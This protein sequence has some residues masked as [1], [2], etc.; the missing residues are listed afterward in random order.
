[1][2]RYH[3]TKEVPLRSS[4]ARVEFRVYDDGSYGYAL[5]SYETLVALYIQDNAP[6]PHHGR[7]IYFGPWFD[8]STTTMGHV[9]KFLEDYANWRVSITE[10]RR[11][12]DDPSSYV[13]RCS[14]RDLWEQRKPYETN[15]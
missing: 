3:V 5:I 15:D 11:H 12:L 8:C 1:M 4:N 7:T 9:R 13:K 6:A 2:T 10:I 14:Q